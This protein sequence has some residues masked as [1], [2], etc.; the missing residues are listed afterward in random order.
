MI[1]IRLL[2]RHR[3]LAPERRRQI[4]HAAPTAR[5]LSVPLCPSSYPSSPF[6]STPPPPPTPP[7]C[8]NLA[9]RT[10]HPL[11]S[12]TRTPTLEAGFARRLSPPR[13][14]A[15]RLPTELAQVDPSMHRVRAPSRAHRAR[16]AST[17]ARVFKTVP[18]FCPRPR[19]RR[20][21]PSRSRRPRSRRPIARSSPRSTRARPA[22]GLGGEDDGAATT[23]TPLD[24]AAAAASSS[25][26]ASVA[27]GVTGRD[28][29]RAVARVVVGCVGTAALSR[30]A[31][32]CDACAR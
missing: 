27:R 19:P 13:S 8:A 23:T 7:L 6:E 24:R 3:A 17:L 20:A 1:S 11:L 16:A 9:N 18:T 26:V 14:R 29:R 15:R 12:P 10:T 5:S 21:S 28:A 32:R 30:R 2:R 31:T 25:W 4:L 22:R